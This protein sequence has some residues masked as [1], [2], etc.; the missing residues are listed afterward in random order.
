[1]NP[2]ATLGPATGIGAAILI[3]AVAIVTVFKAF[4][5]GLKVGADPAIAAGG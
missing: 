4:I 2:I 5:F 3:H 1:M